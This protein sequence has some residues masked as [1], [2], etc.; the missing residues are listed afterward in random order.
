MNFINKSGY[1][2]RELSIE[3]RNKF[4]LTSGHAIG[5][6]Q[7][8]LTVEILLH[9]YIPLIVSI[10]AARSVALPV[11]IQPLVHQIIKALK[12]RLY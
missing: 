1:G 12:D 4:K 6:S 5:I 7:N 9:V 8:S 3:I 10:L 2:S 11:S